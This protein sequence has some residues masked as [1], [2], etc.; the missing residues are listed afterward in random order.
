MSASKDCLITEAIGEEISYPVKASTS[1]YKGS[2]VAIEAGYA[3]PL[4]DGLRFAG[5]ASFQAINTT[6]A[7]V[8]SAGQISVKVR[9]KIK[10]RVYLDNVNKY[11]IGAV[12]YAV[13]DNTFTLAPMSTPVGR[14]VQVDGEA[15]DYAIVEFDANICRENIGGVNGYFMP[16]REVPNEGGVAANNTGVMHGWI[17][18]SVNGP[19]I[20]D[21]IKASRG[22]AYHA[23]LSIV[24]DTADNDSESLQMMGEPFLLD[25]AT[26]PFFFGSKVTLGVGGALGSD[27]IFGIAITD[28]AILA[29]CTDDITF[30]MVDASADMKLYVEKDSAETASA[31]AEV[32]MAD[33]VAVN[34]GFVYDGTYV[35]PYVNGVAGTGLV[36]TNLPDNEGLTPTIEYTA[37]I[38]TSLGCVFGYLD[39]YQIV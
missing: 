16:F 2:A 14:V 12:V 18:T 30:R 19:G 13:D 22:T 9:R 24:T 26:R 33:S 35:Y 25:T 15:T 34:L 10:M 23:G 29:G 37:G 36:V 20:I 21:V 17:R 28:T 31:A 38:A 11:M 7:G 3:L 32:V 6:A 27:L 4:T 1:I 39:A 8:G 5:I